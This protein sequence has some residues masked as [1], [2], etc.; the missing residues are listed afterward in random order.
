M[1]PILSDLTGF[2][3]AATALVTLAISLLICIGVFL[4]I[5]SLIL[6]Y[7]KIDAIVENQNK[8]LKELQ[9]ASNLIEQFIN[10]K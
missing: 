10:N 5:R 7:W 6:W 2:E 4:L 1:K 8:Q 3:S 9:K